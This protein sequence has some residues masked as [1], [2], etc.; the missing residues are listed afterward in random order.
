MGLYWV[1]GHA[2][3]PGNEIADDLARGGSAV[4][5]VRPE[6]AFGVPRQDR[7]RRIRRWLVNQHWV[8]WRGLGNT[9]R[10]VRELISG[11]CLGAKARFLSFNWTK[12]RVF[13]GLLTGHN[14]LRRHLYLMGLSDI[15]LCRRREAEDETSAQILCDCEALASLRYAYLGSFSMDTEDIKI[16]SLGAFWNLSKVTG[17][18]LTDMRHKGPVN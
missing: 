4:K 3:V 15:L 7:R 1:P 8:W 17:P 18:S 6:P 12:S 2:G 5:F 16:I 13:T 11:T 10:R 9:Q 14:T